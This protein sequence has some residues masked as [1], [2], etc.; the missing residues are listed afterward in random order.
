[1]KENRKTSSKQT[2]QQVKSTEKM[3]LLVAYLECSGEM[4]DDDEMKY[5]LKYKI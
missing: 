3:I 5:N 2:K 4:I 1:M